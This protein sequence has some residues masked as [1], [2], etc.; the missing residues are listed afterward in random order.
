MHNQRTECRSFSVGDERQEWMRPASAVMQRRIVPAA[1]RKI[2][3]C[4][5]YVASGRVMAQRD[6]LARETQMFSAVSLRG[7]AV[8]RHP[9]LPIAMIL[10]MRG[11][12]GGIWRQGMRRPWSKYSVGLLKLAVNVNELGNR[13]IYSS[14]S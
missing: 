9:R 12:F 7:T 14:A 5:L 8:I 11:E 3:R 1:S 6:T 2:S 4:V 10:L 13:I